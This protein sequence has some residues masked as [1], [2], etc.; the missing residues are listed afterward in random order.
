MLAQRPERD[1]LRLARPERR[2]LDQAVLDRLGEGRFEFGA[3]V[4]VGPGGGELDQSVG[5]VLARQRPHRAG[6]VPQ[7]HVQPDR[8]DELEGGEIAVGPARAAARTASS[9]TP[10]RGQPDEGDG[11]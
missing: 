3:G 9:A 2:I 7:H 6:H 10:D 5:A 11:A 1:V 8:R 4:G